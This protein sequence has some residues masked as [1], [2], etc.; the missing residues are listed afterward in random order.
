MNKGLELIEAFHLFPLDARP[1][2]G[3]DPP[4]NRSSTR[5][6]E[7]VDG[8]VLAQLGAPDMRVPIAHTLAWPERM[9]TP[10]RAARSGRASA[11]SISRRPTSTRFPGARAWRGRRSTRAARRPPCST[12]PMRSRSPPSSAARSA[13]SISPPSSAET[14]QCYRPDGARRDR[15]RARRRRRGAGARRRGAREGICVDQRPSRLPLSR[16]SAFVLVIG[17]SIF[18][19]ELGHYLVGRACSG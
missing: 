18:V 3:G 1:V 7:Y 13:F 5:M 16:S 15:R 17:P 9:A 10:L 8:S 6:V 2:R 14:L 12:P 11:R 19:H 4:R